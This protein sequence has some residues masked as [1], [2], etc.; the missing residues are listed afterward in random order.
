MKKNYSIFFLLVFLTFLVGD[1][2]SHHHHHE[3]EDKGIIAHENFQ[4]CNL[5][6]FSN[7]N[8]NSFTNYKFNPHSYLT[9]YEIYN[10]DYDLVFYNRSYDHSI[11]LRGPPPTFL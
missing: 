10:K 4:D 11:S 6:L 3:I 2:L 8:S 1:T 7:V 5:C 9:C